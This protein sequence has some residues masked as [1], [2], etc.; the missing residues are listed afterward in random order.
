MS[1]KK[2]GRSKSA[3]AERRHSTISLLFTIV[4]IILI[5]VLGSTAYH[6]TYSIFYEQAIDEE[7]GTDVT[8]TI[9]SDP[10][11]REVGQVLKENG[12]IESVSI[13]V[14]QARFSAYHNEMVGG[15]YILNTSQTPTE[16]MEIIAGI[17]T[18]GQPSQTKEDTESEEAS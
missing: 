2:K 1:E 17:N 8:V 9:P 5:V 4:A 10:T 6:F 14:G 7:P 13:F 16:M 15:T 11:D 3:K 12:L 18:E